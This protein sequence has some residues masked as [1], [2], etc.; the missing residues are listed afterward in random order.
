MLHQKEHGVTCP[1]EQQDVQRKGKGGSREK[2][3]NNRTKNYKRSEQNKEHAVG[4]HQ[5]V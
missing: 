2:P 1:N 5:L 4:E 3:D